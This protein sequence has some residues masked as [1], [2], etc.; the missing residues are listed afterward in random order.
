MKKIQQVGEEDEA[1]W[2]KAGP[3]GSVKVGSA[4]G[5]NVVAPQS[6]VGLFVRLP[7]CPPASL[8]RKTSTPA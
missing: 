3:V 4:A 8:A 7:A 2:K 6:R 5:L 1:P